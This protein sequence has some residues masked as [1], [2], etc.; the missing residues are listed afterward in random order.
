MK[1]FNPFVEI[2]D[3]VE[4]GENCTIWHF[5]RILHGSVIGP[6]CNIGQ[7]VVIGPDVRI[8]KKC[9]I[10]NNV[11]IHKGVTLEDEVFC[12]PGMVFTNVR[13]P[14]AGFPKM[15]QLYPTLI[16]TGATLGGNC[17]VICGITIGKYSFVGAGAV[18]TKSVPAHA[19]VYGNPARFHGYVC[20]CG[21]KLDR[22]LRCP[23]CKR[24][25]QKTDKGIEEV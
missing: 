25:Y 9:K 7:N 20:A 23:Q 24:S 18:V 21:E 15:D 17:T 11:S 1:Y 3:K 13:F 12:G 16:C 22:N 6:D 10:Q 5:S 2:E 19:L 4:L 14:R 8:G